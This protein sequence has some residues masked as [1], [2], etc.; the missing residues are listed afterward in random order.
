MTEV[1]KSWPV[2]TKRALQALWDGGAWILGSL[3]A[4]A[5]RFDF[6]PSAS[7]L[8]TAGA[9]GALLAVVQII[10]GWSVHLYRGRYRIGS[11][12]EASGVTIT[13][14]L[15]AVAGSVLVAIF[16]QDGVPRSLPV[17]AGVL[18]LSIMMAGRVGLRLLRL[19]GQRSQP[20]TRALILG[21]GDMGEHLLRLMFADKDKTFT[22]VAFLDDDPS[23][24]RLRLFGVKVLGTSQDLER[25]AESQDAEVLV[26][27]VTRITSE[28]LQQLDE[29]CSKIGLELRVVPAVATGLGRSVDLTDVSQV[30]VEDLLGR[31]PVQV[32]EEGIKSFISG[33]R[34]LITGAGGSI[35]S[36][37]VRQVRNYAPAAV[38]V[39][40]RDETAIQS[41]QISTDGHGLLNS[42]D[43]ILADIR[44][45]SRLNE[46]MESFAPDVVFHAAALKHLPMLEMYPDEAYKTNVLGTANVLRAAIRTQ[47]KTFVNIS[48]DKAADPTSVLGS[49]KWMTEVMTASVRSPEARYLS[50][51]FGNVLASRGSVLQ[52]FSAQIN[53]GGPVTVTDPAVTRFFMTIPEAVHLVLQASAIGEAGRTLILDMGTPVSIDHVAR[54]LIKRSRKAVTIEYVGLRQGEKLHEVLV[55]AHETPQPTAHDRIISVEVSPIPWSDIE[56][57]ERLASRWS[58]VCQRHS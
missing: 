4:M 38:A 14:V 25:V 2:G 15:I 54:T 39:L 22:P 19:N 41:V 27:A 30:S 43:L 51:R 17:L 7:Q 57:P 29:R 56:S 3:G 44:D 26:V 28:K 12:D 36:E 33:K 50:V 45:Y 55:G 53:T 58:A 10:V 1:W 37:L 52:L 13:V 23:K 49:S 8:L 9:V 11:L 32:D 5:I 6:Q 16:P 47:V 34:V 31:Q 35:G 18:A 40:D 21:A 46:V 24:R 48:T 42:P 20:G